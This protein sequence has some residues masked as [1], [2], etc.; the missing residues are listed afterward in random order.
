VLRLHGAVHQRILCFHSFVAKRAHCQTLFYGLVG[1]VTGE[2]NLALRKI[3]VAVF[4]RGAVLIS[5]LDLPKEVTIIVAGCY[6]LISLSVRCSLNGA[7][8]KK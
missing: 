8:R 1:Y 7:L 6:T 3:A 5:S 4:L 2:E